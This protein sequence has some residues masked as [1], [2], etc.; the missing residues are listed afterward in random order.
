VITNHGSV[1]GFFSNAIN[2]CVDLAHLSKLAHI[3]VPRIRVRGWS[4]NMEV[5]LNWWSC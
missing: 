1:L 4:A 3:P 5:Y 2:L